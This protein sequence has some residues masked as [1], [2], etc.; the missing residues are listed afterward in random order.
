MKITNK[1]IKFLIIL[2]GI[3]LPF[4]VGFGIYQIVKE[5]FPKQNNEAKGIIVGEVLQEAKKDSL[6]LQGLKYNTP[7]EL[8]NSKNTYL[9]ISLMTYKEEKQINKF[10]SLANDV[11]DALLKYV[12]VIFLDENY[13]VVTSLLDKKAS[14]LDI[15]VQR[16]DYKYKNNEV[17][18]TVKFIVYLI[19]FK[20]SNN[21]G[22]LNSIDN[23]DLYISDLNGE[24]LKRISKEIDIKRF[25]FIKSNSQIFIKYTD[26]AI[27]TEEHKKQKFAIYDIKS[28]KFLNMSS[29]DK[30]LDKIEK[31][32]IN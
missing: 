24:N 16:K 31:L 23:H 3:M 28:M 9:P 4:L 5:F 17:D 15:E 10:R 12:N 29:I 20:D 18:K 11:G 27:V 25:E 6:A 21:D 22:K 26:R 2:N 8:Y 1:F 30:E 13:Q 7:I 14:I 19:A 32:I